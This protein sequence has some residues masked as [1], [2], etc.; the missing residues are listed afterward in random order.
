MSARPHINNTV[1]VKPLGLSQVQRSGDTIVD[2]SSPQKMQHVAAAGRLETPGHDLDSQKDTPR[3]QNLSPIHNNNKNV[4]E[5]SKNR[6][7]IGM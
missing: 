5:A 6:E 7:N 4:N 3:H 1:Q 2:P